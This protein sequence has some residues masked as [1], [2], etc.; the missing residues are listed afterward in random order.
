LDGIN[1]ALVR[2]GRIGIVRATLD[3]RE[4]SSGLSRLAWSGVATVYRRGSSPG[5][6]RAIY[7][8]L[9]AGNDYNR[10]SFL[11]SL[12]GR[13]IRKKY[14]NE[15]SP[16]LVS[17]PLMLGILRGR[18][19]LFYQHG[20]LVTPTEAIV[21]GAATLFVPTLESAAPFLA[22]GYRDE[23]IVVTGLCIEP[24]L[25]K[26]AAE[27]QELR[28][29]RYDSNEPLTAAIFSSGAEPIEHIDGIAAL[30]PSLV[31]A[32]YRFLVFAQKGGRLSTVL[33]G[34][35]RDTGLPL[36]RLDTSSSMPVDLPPAV[37]VE[38]SNRR[39]ENTLT[40]RLF[41]FFDFLISPSHERTNWGLGLGLPFFILEP[42]IG[43][44][45]PLNRD[46]LLNHKVAIDL[47]SR[48]QVLGIGE[49]LNSLRHRGELA[50][51]SQNGWGKFRID[52]F[53]RIADWLFDRLAV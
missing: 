46:L 11:L 49:R 26:Q 33:A 8:T 31:R 2:Q 35:M 42:C 38:H 17:H 23:Q 47:S 27:G 18:E 29:A 7:R 16:L 10:E 40:A 19:N 48:E 25:V 12:L 36:A 24:P 9:R 44:Y 50:A 3:A 6:V 22:G 15:S 4:L 21:S 1:D 37:L 28:L 34:A 13:S 14:L 52:G 39:E 30:C 51:M 32:G 43:P 45:A 41:P 53:V 20:E 5:P